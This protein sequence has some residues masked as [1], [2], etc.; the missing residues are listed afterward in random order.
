[1]SHHAS[2]LLHTA[3][4]RAARVLRSFISSRRL[5]R[6]GAIL[7]AALLLTGVGAQAASAYANPFRGDTYRTGRTDMGVDFCLAP[8]EPIRAIGYGVVTGISPN[9]YA[10]QPYL[11]YRLNRGPLAGRYVYVAEQITPLVQVGQRVARGEVIARFA[12]HGTC[13]ESG[14]GTASGWTLAQATT[15][16]HESQRTSAGVSFARLL[17]RLGVHG[18]FQLTAN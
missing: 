7:I 3:S 4:Q 15:G 14:W 8:G 5:G 13:I 2:E 6:Q 17:M 18:P 11:W 10:G 12:S 9:W 16:Y 1:M